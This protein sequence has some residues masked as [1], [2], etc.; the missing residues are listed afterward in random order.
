MHPYISRLAQHPLTI[1]ITCLLAGFI[2]GILMSPWRYSLQVSASDGG[3]AY[4]IDRLTGRTDVT[5][6]RQ[7]WHAIAESPESPARSVAP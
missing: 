5:F 1:P 6:G 3:P 7:P 4:R 2:L